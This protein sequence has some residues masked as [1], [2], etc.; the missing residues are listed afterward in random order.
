MDRRRET[1]NDLPSLPGGG[2]FE[3]DEELREH[4]EHYDA[5]HHT[6]DLSPQADLSG[7]FA[8]KAALSGSRGR[9]PG[10]PTHRAGA[11]EEGVHS[12]APA[13]EPPADS[14]LHP[15]VG[16]AAKASE[17]KSQV[18]GEPVGLKLKALDV[19]RDLL[20]SFQPLNSVHEH[21][22][23]WHFYAHDMSRQKC[24][25]ARLIGVEYIISERL[26][27]ELPEEER[28]YWHSHRYEVSS[29][30]LVAPRVP[31]IAERQDMQKLCGTYG[32][33]WHMWQVDRGDPLPYGP[34]Q[35]MMAFTADGQLRQELLD[36]RDQRYG[37][38]TADKRRQREQ[39]Q[40][41]ERVLPGADHWQSGGSVWQV[42]MEQVPFK[43]SNN[44]EESVDPASSKKS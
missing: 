14:L 10:S 19:G 6:E 16:P 9:E 24:G 22:C 33:T 13:G 43:R 32:K 40:L 17:T 42:T 1:V 44:P 11:G 3:T 12:V 5:E 34:P 26:F 2:L 23:A 35:L 38:S 20:Q 21:V 29:G 18:P 27:A 31:G 15:G 37:I 39:L 7:S 25:R 8:A 4:V 36:E 30:Q 41:P 28:K